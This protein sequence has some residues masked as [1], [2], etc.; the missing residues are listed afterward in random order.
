M[1][2]PRFT[3]PRDKYDTDAPERLN[4]S[5]PSR[6][7][8]LVLELLTW[9]PDRNWPIYPFTQAVLLQNPL[10][11]IAPLRQVLKGNDYE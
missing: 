5:D 9:I 2:T 3:V 10:A 8:H 1:S 6:W 4:S 11:L 7:G